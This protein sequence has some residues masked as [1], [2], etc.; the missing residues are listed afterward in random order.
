MHAIA[1]SH[2]DIM[3]H[4]DAIHTFAKIDEW[5]SHASALTQ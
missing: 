2:H 4:M 1:H 3:R 5:G